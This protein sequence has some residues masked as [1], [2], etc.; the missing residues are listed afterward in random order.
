MNLTKTL[1]GKSQT[2]AQEL[3]DE[4]NEL[5]ATSEQQQTADAARIKE[6]EEKNN[7]HIVW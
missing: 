5:R 4:L 3:Q 6:L 7:Q 2:N 1:L